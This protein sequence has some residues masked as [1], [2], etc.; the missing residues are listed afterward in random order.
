L[1]K[2]NSTNTKIDEQNQS[3][4]TMIRDVNKKINN[5]NLNESPIPSKH[6]NRRKSLEKY[7]DTP[8]QNNSELKINDAEIKK[9]LLNKLLKF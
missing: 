2:K 6:R 3:I 8:N 5:L 7:I 4:R 1:I 9:G